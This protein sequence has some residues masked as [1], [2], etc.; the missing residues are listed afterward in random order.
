MREVEEDAMNRFAKAATW[1]LSTALLCAALIYASIVITGCV[2]N[3][4]SGTQ[5]QS[6]RPSD[7]T[8]PS[9]V[10]PPSDPG[11]NCGDRMTFRDQLDG[12]EIQAITIILGTP[13]SVHVTLEDLAGNE[14]APTDLDATTLDDRI[15]VLRQ[16]EERTLQFAG[17][18]VGGTTAE[19][20]QAGCERFLPI[21]VVN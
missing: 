4:F 11:G 3:E 1:V 21:S 19:V 13:T 2:T 20:T 15:A 8:G 10:A 9:P 5:D 18:A 17:V 7:P 16:R 6:S 12:N 14:L